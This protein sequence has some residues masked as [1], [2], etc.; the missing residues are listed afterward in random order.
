[1][2]VWVAVALVLV[3]SLATGAT[4]NRIPSLEDLLK[5]ERQL[6]GKRIDTPDLDPFG[7]DPVKIRYHPQ[8]DQYLI[9]L[10][11]RSEV[12]LTDRTLNVVDRR[13]TPRSPSGWALVLDRFLFISGELSPDIQLF[14]VT[15]KGLVPGAKF[16]VEGAASIRDLVYVPSMGSLFLLDEFHRR[17][18]QVT[19]PRDWQ[20]QKHFKIEQKTYPLGAGPIQIRAHD[21]HLLINLLLEHTL[22]IVPLFQGQPDFS[23]SSRISHDG[24]IWAFDVVA[25]NDSLVIAAA[26]VENRPLNRL[27]GEFGYIDSFL[28]LYRLS[29]RD[30]FYGWNPTDRDNPKHFTQA[31]LSEIDVI[32]PKAVK[33][34]APSKDS[35]TVWVSAFGSAK[36]ARFKFEQSKILLTET[37]DVFPGTTD[38]VIMPKSQLSGVRNKI[39]QTIIMTN[40]LLDGIYGVKLG[41]DGSEFKR[42]KELPSVPSG[43]SWQS[44]MGELLFFTTLFTPHNRSDGEL[45]RFTCEAC[46]FNGAIDGRVHYTGREHVF[47]ATKPLRGLA[48]NVPLFSRAGDKSLSSMVLAEFRV[49]NQKRRD[50][51]SVDTSNYPWLEGIENLPKVL[52]PRDLRMAFLSFFVEYRH[53]PNPWRLRSE[54]LTP[55]ALQG[56]AVFRERCEY[57]HQA[58]ISTR[59]GDSVPY[60]RWAGWLEAKGKDLVWGAPFYMKTGIKPYVHRAGARVPSLR[61]VQQKYPYFTNGSSPTLLHLL[62]RFRYRDLSAWHHYEESPEDGEVE[63]VKALTADEIERLEELLRFY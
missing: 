42:V 19:L 12:L 20:S 36:M 17:L 11:N 43:L 33:L 40:S 26:G 27:G 62:S 52:S 56:L 59:Q 61:R 60:D 3:I 49:A 48:N 47:A 2:N 14:E 63:K 53:R 29:R 7:S 51:F 46:H 35:F 5:F 45:S 39:H 38:F 9:L 10:K 21:N 8:S 37:F 50:S 24:P 13:V 54:K 1:M 41:G 16:R 30:G 44:R 28:Y 55:K 57:C 32:T 58:I 34:A 18:I 4:T 31:N 6:L 23:R 22:M 15:V 25:Q